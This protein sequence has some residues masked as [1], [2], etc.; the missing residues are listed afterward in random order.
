MIHSLNKALASLGV[1]LTAAGCLNEWGVIRA[2]L[3]SNFRISPLIGLFAK[4]EKITVEEFMSFRP[5]GNDIDRKNR[6]K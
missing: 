6:N 3:L 4:L 5:K 2:V 1:S